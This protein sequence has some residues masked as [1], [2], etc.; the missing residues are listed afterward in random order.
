MGLRN[1]NDMMGALERYLFPCPKDFI[2]LRNP[3]PFSWVVTCDDTPP[4]LATYPSIPTDH[5]PG[6]FFF[7]RARDQP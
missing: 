5:D 7:P 2:G 1:W 6:H 4:L 3:S